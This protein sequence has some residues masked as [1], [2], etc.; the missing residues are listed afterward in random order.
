MSVIL[1]MRTQLV[2]ATN[3]RFEG[4][5]VVLSF[6]E[7]PENPALEA[8]WSNYEMSLEERLQ[9]AEWRAECAAVAEGVTKER[10]IEETAT[11]NE[12]RMA[13]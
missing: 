10:Q 5:S 6:R 7:I 4:A 11:R 9:L 3:I 8:Q 2:E 12:R 1:E 13:A